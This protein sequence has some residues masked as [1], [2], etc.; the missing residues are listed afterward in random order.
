MK[1]ELQSAMPSL[2]QLVE[3]LEIYGLLDVIRS[4]PDVL[5]Y[6]FTPNKDLDW[7]FE[8]LENDMSP[9]YSNDGSSQK[10]LEINSFKALTDAMEQMYFGKKL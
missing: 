8:T 5:R 3:G 1:V 6:A 4:Q 7:V 2:Q 10:S 9:L